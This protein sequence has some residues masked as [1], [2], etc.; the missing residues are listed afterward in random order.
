MSALG[1]SMCFYV[2]IGHEGCD[3]NQTHVFV[4]GDSQSVRPEAQFTPDD[5]FMCE[6]EKERKEVRKREE[7]R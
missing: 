1:T 4:I 7:V 3:D 5:A 2:F 6:R